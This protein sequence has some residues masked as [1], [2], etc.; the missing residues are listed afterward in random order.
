MKRRQFIS[1]AVA[2]RSGIPNSGQKAKVCDGIERGP[3]YIKRLP[4]P[5]GSVNNQQPL[6]TNACFAVLICNCRCQTYVN[7]YW[8][9]V[10]LRRTIKHFHAGLQSRGLDETCFVAESW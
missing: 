7:F 4:P 5:R 9:N 3:T 8:S 10:R 1:L 6:A 2:G